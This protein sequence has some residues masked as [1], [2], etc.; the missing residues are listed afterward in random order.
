VDVGHVPPVQGDDARLGQALALL[1]K[2]VTYAFSTDQTAGNEVAITAYQEDPAR[3]T[4]QVRDSGPAI[5]PDLQKHAFEPFF[6]NA[7]S[8]SG[9]GFSLAI[10]HGIVR[11]LGGD[12]EISSVEGRGNTF[13]LRLPR[14][15]RPPART[16][17][18][19]PAPSELVRARILAVDDQA[20]V[21]H[22]LQRMLRGH[23][24]VCVE[25]AREAL[26]RIEAGDTFD[27]ILSD[28]MMPGMSG[29]DFY[30][31][32]LGRDPDLA[33]RVVFLSGGA[34][35]E[36]ADAFLRSVPNP[37]INKPFTLAV[38]TQKVKE[39]LAAGRELGLRR[40][41]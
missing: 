13:R 4:I 16:V 5:P 14:A 8:S 1:L 38:L 40:S 26:D 41:G 7:A 2:H 3:V 31:A 6:T 20:P 30:E 32:L 15:E 29:L 19:R 24:V 12:I 28:V 37:L 22:V 17:E 39:C 27:L 35:S 25:S 18:P 10:C 36:R 34:V 33:R 21:L 9:A 11:S 23:D